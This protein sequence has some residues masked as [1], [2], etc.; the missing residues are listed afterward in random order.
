[1]NTFKT[2]DEFMKSVDDEKKQQINALR[3]LII[4]SYPGLEEHIKWNSPSYLLNGEDR[5][6]FS[7]RD[8]FPIMIVVHMGATKKEDKKATP[9]LKDTSG[10][11][12]WKSDTRGVM[13]FTNLADIIDKRESFTKIIKQWLALT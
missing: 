5:I 11:I 6:T 9:V 12:E 3:K 2:V 7:V 10:L 8:T 13:S 4:E 1:M